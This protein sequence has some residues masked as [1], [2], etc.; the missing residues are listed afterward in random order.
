M[1][2]MNIVLSRLAG[3]IRPKM[4]HAKIM[5]RCCSEIHLDESKF[6]PCALEGLAEFSHVEVLFHLHG[7]DEA[8]V[9]KGSRRPRGNPNWPRV[10]I[11]AQR[12]KAR[13]TELPQQSASSC[14]LRD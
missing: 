8:S 5:G 13:R 3:F 7:V 4:G 12:G 9:V 11:F 2:P 6:S 1:V 10:G 14:R